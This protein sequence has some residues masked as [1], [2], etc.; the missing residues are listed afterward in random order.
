MRVQECHGQ[1]LETKGFALLCRYTANKDFV[2]SGR[3]AFVDAEP[4]SNDWLTELHAKWNLYFYEKCSRCAVGVGIRRPD[5]DC[6]TLLSKVYGI[7]RPL[8]NEI[9][10]LWSNVYGIVGP[11]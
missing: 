9:V 1:R 2:V 10:L 8:S 6:W 5:R 11:L 3:K 4:Q 7:V